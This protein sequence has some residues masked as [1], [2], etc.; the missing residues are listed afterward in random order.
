MRNSRSLSA[1]LAAACLALASPALATPVTFN[2]PA[3]N[4]GFVPVLSGTQALGDPE[5]D[6]SGPRDIVGDAQNPL[7]FVASDATHIY[8]RLRID[9]DPR[10]NATNFS[11]FGWGCFINQDAD[12]R[13]YE[14][15]TLVDGVNN[16]DRI[17]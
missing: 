7:L 5:G 15:S 14:F 3:D 4:P 11:P 17:S 12:R 6:A 9:E 8:F 2:F 1:A 16:P 10:Q 13:T